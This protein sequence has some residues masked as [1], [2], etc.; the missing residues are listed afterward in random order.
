MEAEADICRILSTPKVGKWFRRVFMTSLIL[1]VWD[2]PLRTFAPE[3]EAAG[4][5][6]DN[7]R[8]DRH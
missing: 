7:K 5:I 4:S 6:L 1:H 2:K 3:I 8:G